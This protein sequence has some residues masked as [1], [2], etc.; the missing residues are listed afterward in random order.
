MKSVRKALF[1]CLALGAFALA[2]PAQAQMYWRVDLGWSKANDADFKD[3]NF[4]ADAL[5]CGDLLCSTPGKV[6]D[7]G[8]SYVLGAGIGYRF[9]PNMRG[10]VTVSYRG[11]YGLSG[12]DG[13]GAQVKSDIT[14]LAFMANAYYDFSTGGVRPYVGAGLG[15]AQNDMDP[16]TVSLPTVVFTL[17]GGK[18]SGAAFALMAG[19]AIPVSGWM[20]DIGYRYIDL[21]KIEAGSGTATVTVTAVPGGSVSFPYSGAEGKLTAHELTLGLRF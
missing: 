11:G 15:W 4:A 12:T 7:A 8:D 3:K 16:V 1:L 2:A 19:V 21:G 20:L 9:N 13:G 10:D 17:P 14:S 6:D 18:K 5:I